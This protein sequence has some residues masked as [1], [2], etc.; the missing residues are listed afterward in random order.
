[1][2]QLRRDFKETPDGCSNYVFNQWE[3]GNNALTKVWEGTAPDIWEQTK[4]CNK[5]ATFSKALGFSFDTS[6][7]KTEVASVSILDEFLGK[8]KSAGLGTI[9][10]EKQKQLNAWAKANNIQ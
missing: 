2:I 1:M 10:A 9:I 3:V 8:L 5:S 4:E 7:V 6:P